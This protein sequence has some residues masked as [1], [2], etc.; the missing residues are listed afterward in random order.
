M[1]FPYD[2]RNYPERKKCGR[3]TV[4]QYVGC[5]LSRRGIAAIRSAARRPSHDVNPQVESHIRFGP[6][7]QGPSTLGF[8]V[9]AGEARLLVMDLAEKERRQGSIA[10]TAFRKLWRHTQGDCIGRMDQTLRSNMAQGP[11]APHFDGRRFFNPYAPRGKTFREVQRWRNT[12][13]KE[14]WPDR[15]EDPMHPSPST[16]R[17]RQHLGD[18]HRTFNLL[19]ADRRHLRAYRSDLVRALQPR[20][21]YRPAPGEAARTKSGSAAGCGHRPGHSQSLRSHGFADASRGAESLGTEGGDGP[22]QCATPRESRHP[23]G[24]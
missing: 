4:S 7:G 1:R 13:R 10:A 3:V 18:V 22:W 5:W 20:F 23:V 9:V 2:C 19:V 8:W 15:V 21:V 12:R 11:D 14:P 16:C 24:D 17:A 6:D